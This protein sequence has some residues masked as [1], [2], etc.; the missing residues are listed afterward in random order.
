MFNSIIVQSASNY[1]DQVRKV[2]FR[3]SQNILHNSTAFDPR[4]GM[5]DLD[6]DLRQ[7]AIA[8]F[9]FG[10]QLFLARLFFG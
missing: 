9:L 7:F 4:N 10:S 8:L 2:V 3:V 5:F 1:H 6:T